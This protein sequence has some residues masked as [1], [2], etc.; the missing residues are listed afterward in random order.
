[1]QREN[2]DLNRLREP[3]VIPVIP[4]NLDS[5]RN[6][7]IFGLTHPEFHPVPRQNLV[8]PIDCPLES[9]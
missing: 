5:R 3:K 9:R 8:R 1:M 4:E 7:G 6:P 2:Q